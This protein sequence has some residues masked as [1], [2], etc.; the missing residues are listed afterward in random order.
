MR[1]QSASIV[2]AAALAAAVLL[3]AAPALAADYSMGPAR[4]TAVVAPDG[5]M[6][7]EERRTFTFNGDFTFVYWAL[8]VG[9]SSGIR[10]DGLSG[11]EGAYQITD[12]PTALDDRPPGTYL[13]TGRGNE[14][15]VRV[16]DV[17]IEIKL[18]N[19]GE[20]VVMSLINRGVLSVRPVTV[21]KPRLLGSKDV[22]T[23]EMTLDR[24][25]SRSSRST[26]RTTWRPSHPR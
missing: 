17:S 24:S 21:S 5:S 22:E 19:P 6:A 26:R 8:D 14:V 20:R 9:G 12:S 1:R 13:V 7:V 3:G 16:S 10:V 2:M 4:I 25:R 15:E 23:F 11:S 18:P